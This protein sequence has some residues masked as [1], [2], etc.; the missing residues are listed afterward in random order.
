MT[1]QPNDEIDKILDWHSRCREEIKTSMPGYAEP[2]WAEEKYAAIVKRH[3]DQAREA[4]QRL[5]VEKELE[6][7][8]K[9]NTLL[10]RQGSEI[11]EAWD[12]A[13][14]YSGEMLSKLQASLKKDSDD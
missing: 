3:K 5:I 12:E 10:V 9:Y 4:I 8:D 14:N 13:A 1:T 7:H 2:K 6:I 11:E